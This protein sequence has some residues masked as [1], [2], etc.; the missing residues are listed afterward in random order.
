MTKELLKGSERYDIS[1]ARSSKFR[2]PK[3]ISVVQ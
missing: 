2:R 3:E 1:N